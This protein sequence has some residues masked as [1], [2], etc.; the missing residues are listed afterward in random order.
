MVLVS[1]LCLDVA[2]QTDSLNQRA[3]FPG[4]ERAFSI[5]WGRAFHV[6]LK[7]RMNPP[8]NEGVIR[9]N[10]ATNGAISQVQIKQSLNPELDAAAI[11][12]VQAMPRWTPAL[13]NGT[14][15]DSFIEFSYF[16]IF[17]NQGTQQ[18]TYEAKDSLARKSGLC[19]DLWGGVSLNTHDLGKYFNPVRAVLGIEFSY[20]QGPFTLGLGWDVFGFS[21]IKK[22]LTANNYQIEEGNKY[23]FNPVYLYLP[24]GYWFESGRKWTIAPMAGP[25]LDLFEFTVRNADTHDRESLTVDSHY[26]FMAGLHLVK[27]VNI[28]EYISARTNRLRYETTYVGIRLMANF[29]QIDKAGF[30]PLKGAV[31]TCSFSTSGFLQRQKRIKRVD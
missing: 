23:R 4:G 2:A 13:E 17:D 14:P 21:K 9:F 3:R 28:D 16:V 29:I 10:V 22:P 31:Y 5:Y 20:R 6:P 1:V 24:V 7:Y 30:T 11:K 12:A 25:A 18:V 27:R 15:T 26:S 8:L 19:M